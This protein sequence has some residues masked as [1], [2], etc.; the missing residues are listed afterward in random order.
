VKSVE[1]LLEELR[2]DI[3]SAISSRQYNTFHERYRTYIDFLTFLISASEYGL[4][5]KFN[6]TLIPGTKMDDR[7]YAVWLA[8]NEEIVDACIGALPDNPDFFRFVAYAPSTYFLNLRNLED[9]EIPRAT[10]ELSLNAFRALGDWWK[11]TVEYQG[12]SDHGKCS[13]A[14]LKPPELGAHTYSLDHFVGS[15]E[16]LRRNWFTG[17]RSLQFDRWKE[18]Q[19]TERLHIAHIGHIGVMIF[20]ALNHGDR[21]GAMSAADMLQSWCNALFL[22]GQ[23]ALDTPH[24]AWELT[25]FDVL[26]KTREQ[27]QELAKRIRTLDEDDGNSVER[28]VGRT[29]LNLWRDHIFVVT[30]ALIRSNVGCKCETS[31]PAELARVLMH[32]TPVSDGVAHLASP[33]ALQTRTDG[34]ESIIRLQLAAVSAPAD[35]E[36]YYTILSTAHQRL[37]RT[38][39]RRVIPGRPYSSGGNS[40][41]ATF[42]G[43]FLLL[44]LLPDSGW[45]PTRHFTDLVARIVGENREM[46]ESLRIHFKVL[47]DRLNLNSFDAYAE[48]F[49]CLS[50][51]SSSDDFKKGRQRLAKQF[52]EIIAIF[53][54]HIDQALAATPVDQKKLD[55]ISKAAKSAFGASG[56]APV[57]FFGKTE[58]T[59]GDTELMN[60]TITD[61]DKS[62]YLKTSPQPPVLIEDGYIEEAMRNNLAF[63]VMRAVQRRMKLHAVETSSA[64]AYWR[65]FMAASADLRKRGLTPVLLLENRVVPRW[66]WQWM[67]SSTSQHAFIPTDLKVVKNEKMDE[68]T[69]YETTINDVDVYEAA[70]EKGSSLI[71]PKEA[72]ETITYR[73]Y[74]KGRLVKVVAEDVKDK[75]SLVDVKLSW[76]FKFEIDERYENLGTKLVYG[77][78]RAEEE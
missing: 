32:G 61:Q 8:L 38:T 28:F 51:G 72:F 71:L 20:D 63:F 56:A 36:T 48:V 44:M 9:I 74:G 67:T 78:R 75:P 59:Q 4:D 34:F 11:K 18:V 41:E 76:G 25:A 10:L 13:P 22:R 35:Q 5:N 53:N 46:A 15:Y 24:R 40:L 69:G 49:K 47:L 1:S 64:E 37:G 73:D 77:I 50:P 54:K 43:Q 33:I 58:K 16:G 17:L 39:D 55:A 21:N 26:A 2:L 70:V 7:V 60:F 42:E 6:L 68:K 29:L 12:F 66:V 65:E 3:L 57:I 14:T 27:A 52:D 19:D 31:L 30:V 23:A 45:N 62:D